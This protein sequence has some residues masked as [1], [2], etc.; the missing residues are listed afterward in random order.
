MA[1][2]LLVLIASGDSNL[3]INDVRILENNANYVGVTRI[4]VDENLREMQNQNTNRK[5][6]E[7]AKRDVAKLLWAIAAGRAR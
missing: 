5:D 3:D 7:L 2:L 1:A 4:V 6:A